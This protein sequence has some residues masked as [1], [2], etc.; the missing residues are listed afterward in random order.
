[1]FTDVL[2]ES[3]HC[4]GTSSR[5]VGDMTCGDPRKVWSNDIMRCNRSV[6]WDCRA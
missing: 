4:N 1:M 3:I 6:R 5:I 2:F